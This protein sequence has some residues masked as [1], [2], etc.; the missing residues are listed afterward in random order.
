M[1]LAMQIFSNDKTVRI[2]TKQ[3]F[4]DFNSQSLSTQAKKENNKFL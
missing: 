3:D 4:E 2:D 1:E